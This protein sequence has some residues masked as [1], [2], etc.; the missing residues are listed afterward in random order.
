MMVAVVGTNVILVANGAHEDVSPECVIE[1]V[2]RLQK[3]MSHGSIAIDDAHRIIDE[4]QNKTSPW[5]GKGAGDVFLRWVLNRLG[6]A[7]RVHQV[8]LTEVSMDRF[9]EFPV[10]DLEQAFD[11][12]DRKFAAVANTHPAKPSIWQAADSKWLDWWPDLHAAGVQVEFLC[13]DD[14]C[15]FYKKKFPNK[16]VPALP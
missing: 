7:K 15:R 14:V 5:Q 10:P 9:L 1:C 12:P 6:D 3:L 4:Y 11:R 13:A 8:S 16:A 2:K